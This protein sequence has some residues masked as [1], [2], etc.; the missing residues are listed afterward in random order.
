MTQITNIGSAYSKAARRRRKKTGSRAMLEA[1]GAAEWTPRDAER[2]DPLEVV[3]EAR[4]RITGIS[5]DNLA[6]ILGE[7]AGVAIHLEA[8]DDSARLWDVYKRFCAALS[9]HSQLVMGRAMFPSA[10]KIEFLP[11]TF[12]TRADDVI[13]TRSQD[14]RIRDAK[15]RMADW[16]NMLG[17]L[18]RN[19]R[20]AIDRAA[21]QQSV[22]H[23]NGSVTTDGRM[24]VDAMR[25]LSDIE[26]GKCVLTD[27]RIVAKV[28]RSAMVMNIDRPRR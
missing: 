22:L 3:R 27:H 8:P 1:Q 18:H 28:P 17:F 9:S 16:V 7:A 5:S 23:V 21:R 19:H 13:D 24:F 10:A 25:K 15:N 4:S 12:E 2:D 26:R 11:E 14:E 20:M 6:P